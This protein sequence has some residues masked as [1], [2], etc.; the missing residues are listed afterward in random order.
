MQFESETQTDFEELLSYDLNS[1]LD[2]DGDEQ[3]EIA[4]M[5]KSMTSI[6]IGHI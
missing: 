6:F 1:L 5:Q 3:I 4:S 2:Y